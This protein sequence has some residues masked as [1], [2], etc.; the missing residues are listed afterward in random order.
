M[1]IE[2]LLETKNLLLLN[3]AG[4]GAIGLKAIMTNRLL[5]AELIFAALV[6]ASFAVVVKALYFDNKDNEEPILR[7]THNDATETIDKVS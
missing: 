4:W 1:R 5:L 6:V 2:L 7:L 3:V